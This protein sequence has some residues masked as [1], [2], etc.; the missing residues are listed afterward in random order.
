[1]MSYL[2]TKNTL[3]SPLKVIIETE[4]KSAVDDKHVVASTSTKADSNTTKV[5]SLSFQKPIDQPQ[6]YVKRYFYDKPTIQ[7]ICTFFCFCFISLLLPFY[8]MYNV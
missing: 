6:L 2:M 5:S 3:R 4:T 8:D 7:T 1:M